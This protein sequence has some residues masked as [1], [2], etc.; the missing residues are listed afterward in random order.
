MA[1]KVAGLLSIFTGLLSHADDA[2]IVLEDVMQG[3]TDVHNVGNLSPGQETVLPGVPFS[4]NGAHF[5][6]EIHIIR[7]DSPNDLGAGK[8]APAQPQPG[9]ANQGQE[10]SS[11]QPSQQNSMTP[12]A[13]P[14]QSASNPPVWNAAA[15]RWELVS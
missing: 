8:P 11:S 7:K 12:T 6:V 5:S 2:G 3:I 15:G 13:Q 10:S 14:S 9:S 4:K 1:L